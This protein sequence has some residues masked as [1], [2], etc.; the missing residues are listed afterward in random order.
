MLKTSSLTFQYTKDD[1]IFSFPDISLENQ[2]N[3]LVIGK[4]GIG[5]TTFL[6]LFAGLLQPVNGTILISDIDI[7][8][9]SHS[10]LDAFRGVHIGLVFQKKYAIQ[11]LNVFQNLQARLLFSKKRINHKEIDVL[12]AQLGLLDFKKSKI[13]KLSEGQLQ[14]LGIALA[15]IHKPKVIL[16]DE[17]TSSLDDENCKIVMDLLLEQASKIGANLIIITHDQRVKPFFKKTVLL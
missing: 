1:P 10:K 7:N 14:R 3:L 4:S 2:E 8:T 12:L 5:K 16:A 6:H 13:N 15:V 9:L 11:N 17:P